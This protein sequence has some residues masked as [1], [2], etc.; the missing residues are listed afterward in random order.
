MEN[1]NSEAL[2]LCNM[3][4]V[5]KVLSYQQFHLIQLTCKKEPRN[6]ALLTGKHRGTYLSNQNYNHK[7]SY[8]YFSIHPF[9]IYWKFAICQILCELTVECL[10]LQGCQTTLKRMTNKKVSEWYYKCYKGLWTLKKWNF[11]L[12]WNLKLNSLKS[13]RWNVHEKK[14]NL[15]AQNHR[16]VEVQRA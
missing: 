7:Q 14:R 5:S 8:I 1:I 3:I 6:E 11:K 10:C 2:L 12:V 9:I 16:I 13:H 4:K 15:W